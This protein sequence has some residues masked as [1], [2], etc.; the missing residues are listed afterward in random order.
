MGLRNLIVAGMATKGT[1]SKG[2]SYK[3]ELYK[4]LSPENIASYNCDDESSESSD[5]EG[6]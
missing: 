2:A 4:A 3:K 5:G 6:Y 1:Q